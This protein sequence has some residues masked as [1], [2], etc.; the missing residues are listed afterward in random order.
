M[1]SYVEENYLGKYHREELIEIYLPYLSY[2][3]S[4]FSS[5]EQ[6]AQVRFQ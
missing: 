1:V 5:D 4:I 2:I 3:V 6:L